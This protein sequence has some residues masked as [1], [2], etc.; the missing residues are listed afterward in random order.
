MG[1]LV[2]RRR[3]SIT[4][5]ELRRVSITRSELIYKLILHHLIQAISHVNKIEDNVIVKRDLM[6]LSGAEDND[7]ANAIF[8][9]QTRPI[10][11]SY[12]AKTRH[13]AILHDVTCDLP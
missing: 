12:S 2:S 6:H 9:C 8:C 1:Y 10:V 4:R 11:A 5:S 3:V 7:G 13:Y